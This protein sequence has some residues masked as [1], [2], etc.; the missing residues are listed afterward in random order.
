M[1]DCQP[2]ISTLRNN[3]GDPS[4]HR[5]ACPSAGLSVI[6][7]KPILI[8]DDGSEP[9]KPIYRVRNWQ[10]GDTKV[11]IAGRLNSTVI[12]PEEHPAVYR[13]VDDFCEILKIE[14]WRLNSPHFCLVRKRTDP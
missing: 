1:I 8:L 6:H 4:G 2:S 12:D 9:S 5:P 3:S 7:G 11:E 13:S 10:F 14:S